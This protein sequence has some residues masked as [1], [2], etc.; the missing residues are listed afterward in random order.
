[1]V[2]SARVSFEVQVKSE[3]DKLNRQLSQT[4]D[5]LGKVRRDS[6]KTAKA[7]QSIADGFGQLRGVIGGVAAAL[8]AAKIVEWF[9]DAARAGLQFNA[10]IEST[11]VAFSVLTGSSE[12][13]KKKVQALFDY[14]AKTPFEFGNVAEAARA[15]ET[16]GINAEKNL[17]WIGDLAAAN[18]QATIDEVGRAIARLASGD[19]GEAFERLRDF[20]ISK[21]LLQGEGL[22]FDKSGSYKG[23]VE[24]A[25]A[26]VERIVT[27]RYAGMAAAQ[28]QTFDGML[29]TIRDNMN[30]KAGELFRPLF[31]EA[32]NL[33][34]AI[35]A[36]LG[37]MDVS[38]ASSTLKDLIGGVKEIVT[39][40]EFVASLK[41][42]AGAAAD[43]VKAY[44]ELIKYQ[45]D[46]GQSAKN[47]TNI[48]KLLELQFRYNKVQIDA[49]RIATMLLKGDVTGL[50]KEYIGAMKKIGN[51]IGKAFH[52]QGNLGDSMA[53]SLTAWYNDLV[54]T[55]NRVIKEF[56]KLPGKDISTLHP[57]SRGGKSQPPRR[58]GAFAQ[59]GIVYSPQ[60]ARVAEFG[61]ERITPLKN[62][63]M[64]A[65][66]NV[67]VNLSGGSSYDAYRAAEA[68]AYSGLRRAQ[69]EAQMMGA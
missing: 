57:I 53:K 17:K 32:K 69:L 68:G 60:W 66:V 11:E 12:V 6:A 56:N 3:L 41:D 48:M 30:S 37:E 55:V 46:S 36:S 10:K 59:G 23:S 64:A 50:A 16:V 45:N 5:K 52:I 61:P 9:T 42:A 25:L 49:Q 58:G 2:R 47:A 4:N 7:T 38:G 34:P 1:M 15:L 65:T 29:S 62:E 31:D 33:G 40:P 21:K 54:G 24:D 26:A 44:V 19:F 8:G 35:I 13:A 43:L 27:K 67:T 20:G 22:K 28:G 39:D 14:A 18:P 63:R 51:A